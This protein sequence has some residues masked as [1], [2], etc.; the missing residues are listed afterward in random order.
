MILL[1]DAQPEAEFNAWLDRARR[2]AAPPVD[3]FAARGEQVFMNNACVLCHNIRGTGAH[4]LVGPDLTHFGSRKGLASNSYPNSTGFVAGW[5]T[6]AQTMKPDAQMPNI[7]AFTGED[8]RA[9][10]TYLEGL[11]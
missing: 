9:L 1:V 8:L 11:K 6:H 7:T 3:S 4:G 5:V 10:V 2:P